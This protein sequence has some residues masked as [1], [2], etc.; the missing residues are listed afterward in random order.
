MFEVLNLT[1]DDIIGL[2]IEGKIEAKDYEKLNPILNKT[3]KEH[4]K[5]KLYLEIDRI[6]GIEPKAVIEDIK[7]Y[8]NHVKHLKKVAVVGRE[9]MEKSLTKVAH[10]FVNAD[11]R[12]FPIQN[13]IIAKEWLH[14]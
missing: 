1:K 2:K 9:G 12:Y 7:A 5:I 3:E 8:F 13:A 4:D 6:D 10:P 14:L 11:V